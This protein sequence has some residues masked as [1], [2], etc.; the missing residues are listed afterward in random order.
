MAPGDDG[1]Q[2][3]ATERETVSGWLGRQPYAATIAGLGYSASEIAEVSGRLVD[4]VV[5]HGDST[6]IAV[7][8]SEH[9]AAG[10]D[11]VTLLPAV[12]GEFAAG[13]DQLERLAPALAEFD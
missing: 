9:L 2:A 12:G 13:V 10:A 1:G 11:H 8:A 6:A 3:K 4:A 5:A 7:K